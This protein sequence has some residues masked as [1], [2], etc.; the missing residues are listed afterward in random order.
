MIVNND[1]FAETLTSGVEQSTDMEIDETDK[2]ILQMILSEG[3]YSDPIG[4][5]IREYTSNALDANRE[6]NNDEPIIVSLKADAQG[7]NWF[8]VQDFG[9]G[10]SPERVK[11]V[12]SKYAASTKRGA[13]NQLGYFGLGMKSGLAYADSFN[14]ETIFDGVKYIYM[15]YKAEHNTKIDLI[16]SFETEEGNGTTISIA[17]K[18]G[19]KRWSWDT[20]NKDSEYDEF[21]KKIKEQLAYF[22][23][24]YFDID[25]FDNNF[26][27]TTT[28]LWKYSPLVNSDHMHL[29]LDNVYYPIDWE[30]L[31]MEAINFPVGLNFKV[32]DGLIPTPNRE[33]LRMTP[34]IKEKIKER[35]K[36]VADEFVI[37]Y[38]QTVEAKDTIMDVWNFID[39]EEHIV[40]ITESKFAKIKA[41]KTVSE[42][43][44]EKVSV[45]GIKLLNLKRV[46]S[47]GD[48][49][50][51]DIINLRG[52]VVAHTYNG[53]NDYIFS[54]ARLMKPEEYPFY[55]ITEKPSGIVIDYIKEKLGKAFFVSKAK[56]TKL[57]FKH[58]NSN[59][60]G[61]EWDPNGYYSMLELNKYPKSQWR[62]IITEYQLVVSQ[63]ES[64][65]KD[66]SVIVP[67]DEY[68]AERKARRAKT[69]RTT[70]DKVEI[71]PKIG[72]K[73]GRAGQNVTFKDNSIWNIQKL[74]QFKGTVIY[75]CDKVKLDKFYKSF[76]ELNIIYN[77]R[78]KGKN[79]SSPNCRISLALL[80]TRDFNKLKNLNIH[81][82][83]SLDNFMKGDNKIFRQYITAYR[84]HSFMGDSGLF[85]V[86][87]LKDIKQLSTQFYN[88]IKELDTYVN[89][90]S[91]YYHDSE[92][93]KS[94]LQLAKDN[95]LWDKSIMSTFNYV[96]NNIH[97]FDFLNTISGN[98]YGLRDEE[99]A[100]CIEILRGRK[101]RMNW[102]NYNVKFNKEIEESI[103]KIEPKEEIVESILEEEENILEEGSA[104]AIV[105]DTDYQEKE[106]AEL[107]LQTE[108]F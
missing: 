83:L 1:N 22:E 96:K 104:E 31:G 8:K 13:A 65:I 9:V 55:F 21:L 76:G 57:G 103:F 98:Y 32:T 46:R 29:C 48:T 47:L 27:I 25:G 99:L 79:Y 62:Q 101:V 26:Q 72:Y 64:L 100:L 82:W 12:I 108:T 91:T 39:S 73:A 38:N 17:L 85:G 33:Q 84:I 43:P 94:A 88:K 19:K 51:K 61:R 34:T 78:S 4:S 71:N 105:D 70:I 15:M 44:I 52:Y 40:S 16:S 97:L 63:F 30:K 87:N 106:L 66:V 37:K 28:E 18:Q 49:V 56:E 107:D 10:M 5:L 86:Q 59:W 74:H 80:T 45:K 6:V 42:I 81:N 77:R 92:F 11:N 20:T 95:D 23:G 68:L 35:I 24:V 3:L 14:I 90:I 7:K 69:V 2:G 54:L 36:S 89:K 102:K 50:I 41:F 75:D 93:V 60:N 53:C 67:T 58:I